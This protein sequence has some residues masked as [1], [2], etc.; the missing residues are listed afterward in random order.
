MVYFDA[1]RGTELWIRYSF[2]EE[3]VGAFGF[4]SAESGSTALIPPV[5]YM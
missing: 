5:V 1:L 4:N 3:K 2:K